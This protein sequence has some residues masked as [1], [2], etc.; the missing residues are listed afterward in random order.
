MT[1]SRK[2]ETTDADRRAARSAWM[3]G[4]KW[5]RWTDRLKDEFL[6]AL[7]ATCHVRNSAA[8]IG[9]EPSSVYQLRR[10]DEA[11][12]AA[13]SVALGQGYEMLELQLVGHAL[14]GGG[15]GAGEVLDNGDPARPPID[16]EMA[17][18]LLRDHRSRA[19][20]KQDVS[21]PKPMIATRE[22]TNAAIIKKLAAIEKRL[23]RE[24]AAGASAETTGDGAESL[25]CRAP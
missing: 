20:G 13:W 21:G 4:R 17:M 19:T 3:T 5:V 12:A 7:A 10:R 1:T 18:K 11:F 16:V 15:M 9:V 22:Q 8:A 25:D 23:A 24:Q 6:D 2:G 14:A